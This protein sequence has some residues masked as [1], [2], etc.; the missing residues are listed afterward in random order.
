MQ[1]V[2]RRV[3]A[4]ASDSRTVEGMTRDEVCRRFAPKVQLI[5]RRIWDRLYPE[6]PVGLEDLVSLGALGLLE[7][8]DR[9]DPSRGIRFTTF[10]EYRIRGA[11]YDGLREADVVSRRR[12]QGAKAVER[13]EDEL[14]R[15][16]GRRPSPEEVADRLGV[17]LEDYFAA[18]DVAT[19]AALRSAEGDP[20]GAAID[21][22]PDQR[23]ALPPDRIVAHELRVALKEAIR[24]LPER[25]QQ[26]IVLYYAK[27]LQLTEIAAVFEVTPS[28]VSQILTEA[29][30]AL[31]KKL[32][33][34]S[35]DALD[36][37]L[38]GEP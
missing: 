29:R 31:R 4:Y 27:E 3:A 26:A 2:I 21:A 7:A 30:S 8:F 10:A 23:A 1:S 18:R 37:Q 12:R 15:E 20:D 16:L 11:I 17:S 24:E 5:A 28:R 36:A 19:R 14:E 22:L 25:Q 35:F 13:A 33:L 9:F 34:R 32:S 38:E 6:G